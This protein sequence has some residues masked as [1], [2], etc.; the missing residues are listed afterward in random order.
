MGGGT[1]YL[2][3]EDGGHEAEGDG[4]G[5]FLVDPRNADA[6]RRPDLLL[7]VVDS[8]H[9]SGDVEQN[10]LRVAVDQPATIYHLSTPTHTRSTQPCIPP[11]SLNRIPALLG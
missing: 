8:P 9:S 6:R 5:G 2:G 10:H 1:V 7:P 4:V 11:G 3:E